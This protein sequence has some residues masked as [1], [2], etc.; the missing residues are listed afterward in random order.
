MPEILSICI[1]TYNRAAYLKELL[2]RLIPELEQTA[3]ARDL[4][5]LYISDNAST[6][7]TPDVIDS[8]R[9][10]W[11]IVANRNATNIGGDHNFAQMIHQAP[12]L[13]FWLLGDDELIVPGILAPLLE[14]LQ[15]SQ[16]HL[17]I[18]E[19][20]TEVGASY[21]SWKAQDPATFADYAAFVDYYRKSDPWK[22]MVH[23]FISMMVIKH[24]IYDQAEARRVLATVDKNYAHMYGL[25]EGLR[26]KPGTIYRLATPAIC[27]RDRRAPGDTSI[28]HVQY[29]WA[30]YYRWL[31]CKFGHPSLAAYGKGLFQWRHWCALLL[32]RIKNAL[33]LGARLTR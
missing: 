19:A 15:T 32:E 3:A 14:T 18:L 17:V 31:G 27:I 25:V 6:D 21:A 29:L 9:E 10:R 26:H 12:G 23:S 13:Y 16:H 5:R 7:A 28:L 30:R 22:L 20:V 33:G 2:D 24:A 11:P 4:V 8:F 1:P